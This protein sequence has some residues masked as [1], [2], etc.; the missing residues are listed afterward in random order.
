M[1]PAR[2]K[3]DPGDP[4][5]WHCKWHVSPGQFCADAKQTSANVDHVTECYQRR[6]LGGRV[7]VET[8]VRIHWLWTGTAE[9]D[10]H[11]I[12]EHRSHPLLIPLYQSIVGERGTAWAAQGPPAQP[13]QTAHRHAQVPGVHSTRKSHGEVHLDQELFLLGRIRRV[14]QVS[15]KDVGWPEPVATF[16]LEHPRTLE[17][18]RWRVDQAV[19]PGLREFQLGSD[20]QAQTCSS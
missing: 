13:N 16:T 4:D 14:P 5:L 2:L 12:P 18:V 6:V 1:L 10:Q 8:W 20:P 7:R 19:Q 11:R 15:G 17:Q 9:L 3:T